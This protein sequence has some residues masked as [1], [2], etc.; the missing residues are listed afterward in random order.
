MRRLRKTRKTAL[1]PATRASGTKPWSSQLDRWNRLRESS[2]GA[3]MDSRGQQ[4]LQKASMC[5]EAPAKWGSV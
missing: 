3:S 1:P 5:P 2:S 4:T